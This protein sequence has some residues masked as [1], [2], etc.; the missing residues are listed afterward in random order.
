MSE[1]F[2]VLCQHGQFERE[3]KEN[4]PG[5]AVPLIYIQVL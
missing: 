4:I 1:P 3:L 5:K 2:L